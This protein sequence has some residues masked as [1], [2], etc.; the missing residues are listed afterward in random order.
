MVFNVQNISK[1]SPMF[2]RTER[3][4]K[5]FKRS[6]K[7]SKR[8]SRFRRLP[9][10]LL[11]L[12][13]LQ[14][15]FYPQNTSKRYSMPRTCVMK[16]YRPSHLQDGEDGL[17]VLQTYNIT[18]NPSRHRKPFGCL[19][20]LEIFQTQK[21]IW[22]FSRH[23][24]PFCGLLDTKNSLEAFQAQKTVLGPKTVWWAFQAKN[25]VWRYSKHLT[26]AWGPQH[27]EDCL[28]VFQTQ[29]IVWRFVHRSSKHR[30]RSSVFQT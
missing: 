8:S 25:T 21:T 16:I 22:E 14:E 29:K 12:E 10:G 9:R 24:R 30:S 7:T 28:L 2:G 1:R 23:R 19:L 13:G 26:T 17:E 15:V 5:T 6:Q 20:R 11:C 18:W 3:S 27:I 4:Q